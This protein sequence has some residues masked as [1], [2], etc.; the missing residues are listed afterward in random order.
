MNAAPKH[1]AANV[2]PSPEHVGPWPLQRDCAR[3]FGNPFHTGWQAEHLERVTPPFLMRM[4]TIRISSI[5]VNK[6]AAASLTRV[7]AHLWQRADFSQATIDK[8]GVSAFSGSFA[9]RS[10]RG[11]NTVSMH[12]YGLAI[13]FNAPHNPLGTIGR[14]GEFTAES[15]LVKAFKAEGW[16][17][18]GDWKTRPDPMHVQAARV[19]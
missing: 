9:L 14:A 7:L 16:I 3:L 2:P 12:A 15:E 5:A 8:W 13:D 18:G 17:W 11:L 10:M 4:G 1:P 6:I 19:G